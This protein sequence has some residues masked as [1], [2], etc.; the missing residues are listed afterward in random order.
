MSISGFVADV[1]GTLPTLRV[2]ASTLVRAAGRRLARAFTRGELVR[3]IDETYR[4]IYRMEEA[5]QSAPTPPVQERQGIINRPTSD[6]TF[7]IWGHDLN[8]LGIEQIEIFQI[9]GRL[10]IHPEMVS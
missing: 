5:C 10:W 6:G 3:L 1:M 9:D 2:V 4:E 7:G 8:D